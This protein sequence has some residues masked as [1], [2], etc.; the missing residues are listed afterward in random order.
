[1]DC[2]EH[3][4]VVRKPRNSGERFPVCAVLE[5]RNPK[6]LFRFSAL[7]LFRLEVR[8][9]L[10]LLFQEPPRTTRLLGRCPTED[11]I[12]QQIVSIPSTVQH[13]HVS[14]PRVKSLAHTRHVPDAIAKRPLITAHPFPNL[15]QI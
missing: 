13:P 10:A 9:F 5:S 6:L 7:F 4:P 12:T 2:T 15:P 14:Q 3:A 8:V 11:H 1:M